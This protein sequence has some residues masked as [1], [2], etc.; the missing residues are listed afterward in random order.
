MTRWSIAV[1]APTS[2]SPLFRGHACIALVTLDPKLAAWIPLLR[3]CAPKTANAVSRN[4][5]TSA[6]AAPAAPRPGAAGAM[7]TANAV[8]ALPAVR[9]T[10]V[11]RAPTNLV[12]M[13]TPMAAVETLITVD[14]E[15][16]EVA[17]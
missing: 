4:Q 9:K 1:S 16:P 2:A 11:A 17:G 14:L 3:E 10:D 6:K 7:S 13:E 8:T 5:G 15:L 12:S